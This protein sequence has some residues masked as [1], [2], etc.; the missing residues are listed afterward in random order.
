LADEDFLALSESFRASLAL[1]IALDINSST[2]VED[3]QPPGR[4]GWI[5]RLGEGRDPH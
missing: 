1:I 5:P 4:V 3:S 2:S